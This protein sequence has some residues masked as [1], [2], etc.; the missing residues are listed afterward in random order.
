TYIMVMTN[1]FSSG[2]KKHAFFGLRIPADFEIIDSSGMPVSP[3]SVLESFWDLIVRNYYSRIDDLSFDILPGLRF[4]MDLSCLTQGYGLREVWGRTLMMRGT[5]RIYISADG[6]DLSAL[7]RQIPYMKRFEDVGELAI[8][9]FPAGTP[10]VALAAQDLEQRP[11]IRL[12]VRQKDGSL[13]G[14]TS[15]RDTV[16]LSPFEY[17]YDKEAYEDTSVEISADDILAAFSA[18]HTVLSMPDGSTVRLRPTEGLAEVEL[19]VKPRHKTV[20]IAV[21]VDGNRSDERNSKLYDS[22]YCRFGNGHEKSLG[23][24]RLEFTG[25]SILGFMAFSK[26]KAALKGTFSFRGDG[27]DV[28]SVDLVG[29]NLIVDLR[30][31]KPMQA[32]DAAPGAIPIQQRG[33]EILYF[34]FEHKSGKCP[35]NTV[36]TISTGNQSCQIEAIYRGV[37]LKHED[38]EVSGEIKL[39]CPP[40]ISATL[41]IGHPAKYAGRITEGRD[42]YNGII[43][44]ARLERI[45]AF[46]RFTELFDYRRS[47]TL[48]DGWYAIRAIIIIFGVL[49]AFATGVVVGWYYHS[50]IDAV[51]VP[52]SESPLDAAKE[53]PEAPE[54]SFAEIQPEAKPDSTLVKMNDTSDIATKSDAQCLQNLPEP[55]IIRSES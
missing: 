4:D 49:F 13:S 20:H 35:A 50:D 37:E 31:L 38:G 21:T 9:H 16:R 25:D 39:P 1:A 42:Q 24:R 14:A 43:Y 40:G 53:S 11:E 46:R 15:I 54:A 51:L 36:A 12:R 19:A 44:E 23:S 29:D 33:A 26:N 17:G 45:S 48:S 5:E 18:G 28:E 47:V 22:L 34:S 7:M 52:A 30:R 55:N 10:T 41:S 27:Y 3:F 6:L 2:R 8:G 32:K